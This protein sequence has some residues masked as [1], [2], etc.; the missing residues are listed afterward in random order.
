M[1]SILAALFAAGVLVTA[2][3]AA[4]SYQ[5]PD[6]NYPEGCFHKGKLHEAGS[7][8]TTDDCVECSCSSKRYMQCCSIGGKP[9]YN[10]E[11]CTATFDKETC[12]YTVHQNPT[13]SEPCD[14]YV[15]VG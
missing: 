1:N 9:I 11:K 13:S 4:C 12:Q 2:C 15:M 3:N 10:K 7:E 14:G 6:S 5:A 8:W